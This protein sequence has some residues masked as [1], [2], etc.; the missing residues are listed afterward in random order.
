M[1]D[2]K[3][4][5][6]LLSEPPVA[7]HVVDAGRERLEAAYSASASASASASTSASARPVPIAAATRRRRTTRT[8]RWTALGAGLLGAAAAVTL[9]LGSATP[10]APPTGHGTVRP[11]ALS[12]EQILLAAA[13]S[14]AQTPARGAYWTRTT[15]NGKQRLEPDGRY[16][17]ERSA[18]VELWLAMA[19]G[20]QSRLVT[21]DQGV[22]PAT[23]RDEQAWRAAGSPRAWTYPAQGKDRPRVTLS[24]DPAEPVVTRL[25]G[26]D[27]ATLVGRPMTRAALSRLPATPEGL[28]AYLESAIAKQYGKEYATIDVEGELFQN[29]ARIVMD[30]PVSAEVRAAAYRMMAK[31]SGVTAQGEVTDPLG[32][33]GQGIGRRLPNGE[34]QFVV[35]PGTGRALAFV[36]TIVGPDGTRSRTY[37]AVTRSAWTDAGPQDGDQEP[38]A[39]G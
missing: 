28:R 1:D 10:T 38:P 2:L 37:S 21:R 20:G 32:R 3:E 30:L 35:D 17:L 25:D 29:G 6:G 15:V 7:A 36:S 9:L 12:A 18:S 19:S 5:R 11:M 22:K 34:E 13:S 16:M 26:D 4:I 27:L 14:T 31:L 39:S 8:A 23:A 33:G 24:A